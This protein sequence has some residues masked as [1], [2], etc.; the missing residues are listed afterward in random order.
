MTERSWLRRRRLSTKEQIE[1]N[2]TAADA[3][4]AG[5]RKVAFP[6]RQLNALRAKRLV[7]ILKPY[8]NIMRHDVYMTDRGWRF[9]SDPKLQALRRLGGAGE[10]RNVAGLR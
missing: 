6:S 1:L 9:V 3:V 2:K 8:A 4:S 7:S 10:T 5:K